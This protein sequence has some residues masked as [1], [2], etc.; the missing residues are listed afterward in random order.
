MILPLITRITP[1][2]IQVFL[3]HQA[4]RLNG[5]EIWINSCNEES[6]ADGRLIGL[7]LVTG[8]IVNCV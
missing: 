5:L 3:S 8:D 1:G 6:D 2:K 7:E 4:F